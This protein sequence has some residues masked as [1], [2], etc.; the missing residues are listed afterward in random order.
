[1]ENST[2]ATWD[3]LELSASDIVEMSSEE[4][5]DVQGAW[6]PIFAAGI[7]LGFAIGSRIWP[8]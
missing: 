5:E 6:L 4:L 2:F 8:K 3:D 1:M 7:G